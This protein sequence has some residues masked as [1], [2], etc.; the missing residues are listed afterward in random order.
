MTKYRQFF[1]SFLTNRH[2]YVFLNRTQS[3]CRPINWGVS[4]GSVLSPLLFTLYIDD[5]NR[6]SNSAPRLYA[7]NTCLIL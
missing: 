2:Q 4:Q 6:A 5:I 7:N 3:N 1:A